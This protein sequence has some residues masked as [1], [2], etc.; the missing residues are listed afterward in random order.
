MQDKKLSLK[1]EASL[2]LYSTT[3][4]RVSRLTHTISCAV[5]DVIFSSD[6]I[7]IVAL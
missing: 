4:G 6:E 1:Y 3:H 7:C 5:L 2:T